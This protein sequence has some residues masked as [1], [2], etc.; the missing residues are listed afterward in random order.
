MDKLKLMY[1]MRPLLDIKETKKDE[2]K[3]FDLLIRQIDR[4][5]KVLRAIDF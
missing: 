2:D 1:G 4:I 3:K 5:A